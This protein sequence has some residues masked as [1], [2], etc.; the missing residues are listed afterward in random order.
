MIFNQYLKEKQKI[1]K[2][3]ELMY[4]LEFIKGKKINTSNKLMMLS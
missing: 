4:R 1:K 3:Q 2:Q